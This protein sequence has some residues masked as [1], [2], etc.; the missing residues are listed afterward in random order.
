MAVFPSTLATVEAT[1]G[2]WE[3]HAVEGL[4]F[5]TNLDEFDVAIESNSV[6]A[7]VA[8]AQLQTEIC[9]D[10]GAFSTFASPPSMSA[11]C[12][13]C[14][15]PA[16]VPPLPLPEWAAA[17]F[18]SSAQQSDTSEEDAARCKADVCHPGG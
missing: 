6:V 12:S 3:T 9:G 2:L 15:T 18:A 16:F 13:A 1:P 17:T 8:P 10:C 4:I 5:V 11:L 14:C 7:E